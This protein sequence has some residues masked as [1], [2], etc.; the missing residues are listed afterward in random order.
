MVQLRAVWHVSED[1]L[2]R[3]D[4]SG[5]CYQDRCAVSNRL[6]APRAR[7]SA[8]SFGSTLLVMIN[9]HHESVPFMLP[10]IP[11]GDRWRL[12]ID[13]NQPLW[14]R[15]RQPNPET[16]VDISGRSLTLWELQ[17]PRSLKTDQDEALTEFVTGAPTPLVDSREDV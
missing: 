14:A 6:N 2:G 17:S 16:A 5:S 9:A 8:V 12:L 15:R 10:S 1:T 11:G 3:E 7:G 13:T 4:E